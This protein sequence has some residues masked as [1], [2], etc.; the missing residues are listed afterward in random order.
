LKKQL[1]LGCGPQLGYIPRGVLNNAIINGGACH[2]RVA[3]SP[4]A[5]PSIPR[6]KRRQ[7]ILVA[8]LPPQ[9]PCKNAAVGTIMAR[10]IQPL[11]EEIVDG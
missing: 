10:E 9:P 3:A 7:I 11:R 5:A 4:V 1:S 6:K 2:H 8:L